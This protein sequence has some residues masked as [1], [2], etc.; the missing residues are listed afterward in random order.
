MAEVYVHVRS[1][2]V[3]ERGDLCVA[4]RLDLGGG[5]AGGGCA[6]ESCCAVLVLGEQWDFQSRRAPLYLNALFF[7]FFLSALQSL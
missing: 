6:G 4:W 2:D 3:A 1:L 7:F 5:L